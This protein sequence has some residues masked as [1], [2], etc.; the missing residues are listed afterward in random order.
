MKGDLAVMRG[1]NRSQLGFERSV[2]LGAHPPCL[3]S[4]VG[5]GGFSPASKDMRFDA[6]I[7]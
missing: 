3:S 2:F 1:G 5:A 4:M 7:A 6:A